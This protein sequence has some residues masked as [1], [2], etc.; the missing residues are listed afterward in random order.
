MRT[1]LA[2]LARKVS[3][4][5]Q[6]RAGFVL[7][8]RLLVRRG[9]V[10]LERLGSEYGGWYVPVALLGRD[11]VVYSVGV[12]EDVT[13]DAELHRRCG[14]IIHAF[15]PT[16][17]AQRYVER[18][19][20]AGITFHPYG[21]WS[22]EGTVRF[23]APQD[24]SHV[25]HSILNLQGTEAFFEGEV[26]TLRAAM[27]ELG[28]QRIDLL[29]MDIEGAE[30][31]VLYDMLATGVRPRI[32]CVELEHPSPVRNVRTV[33]TLRRAGYDVSRVDG[34]NVTLMLREV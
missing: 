6:R 4:M 22:S 21:I 32:V 20:P 9:D 18:I 3:A 8:D 26:R 25:S 28:H 12:G 31:A 2:A 33:L 29:K 7:I 30:Y 11:S 19:Q 23:Y 15:D 16:P 14:C 5:L 17:R 13:F 1:K 27:E 24:P 10:R 34:R